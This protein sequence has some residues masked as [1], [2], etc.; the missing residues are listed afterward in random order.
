MFTVQMASGFSGVHL[1]LVFSNGTA[2]TPGASAGT[3]VA[4]TTTETTTTT[5]TENQ[6]EGEE[7]TPAGEDETTT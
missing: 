3:F 6:T 7:T 4:D 1:G 2:Q 5:G